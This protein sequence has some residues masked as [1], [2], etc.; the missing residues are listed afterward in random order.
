MRPRQAGPKEGTGSAGIPYGKRDMGRLRHGQQQ[1][2]MAQDKP[3]CCKLDIQTQIIIL[4]WKKAAELQRWCGVGEQIWGR[5]CWVVPL[6]LLRGMGLVVTGGQRG[7][8]APEVVSI[9]SPLLK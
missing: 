6:T 4:Q 3:K 9:H 7:L 5:L 1:I 2:G 8:K